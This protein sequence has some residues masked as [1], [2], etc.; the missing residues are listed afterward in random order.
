[1]SNPKITPVM[2]RYIL[3]W[4]EM[5]VKWGVNRT[6]AQIHA[7]LYLSPDPL[8]A[9]QICE[10]LSVA[11]SG[12]STSIKELL[13]WR[14]IA[15]EPRLGDR[16]DYFTV[17]GDTWDMLMTIVEERQKRELAP[18]QAMLHQCIEE[19]K[20]DPDTPPLVKRKIQSMADFLDEVCQWLDDMK[21]LP[22]GALETLLRMGAAIVRLIPTR[23]KRSDE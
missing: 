9:D 8:N 2:Q 3:H 7:L 1:M 20:N 14:L 5:G 21:K 11:R 19:M 16:K 10:V 12:V 23:G 18:T 13:S 4:G 22:R 6:V 15:V 17:K